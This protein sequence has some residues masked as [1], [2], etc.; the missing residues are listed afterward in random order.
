MYQKNF[1]KSLPS[2][3]LHMNAIIQDKILATERKKEWWYLYVYK[4][5]DSIEQGDCHWDWSYQFV[6]VNEMWNITDKTNHNKH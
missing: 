6:F 1:F 2:N 4:V 3:L 5:Y